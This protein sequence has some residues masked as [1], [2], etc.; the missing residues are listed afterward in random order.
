MNLNLSD[1]IPATHSREFGRE[2][3]V[4]FLNRSKTR[5]TGLVV[6]NK[7]ALEL[8]GLKDGD[9]VQV[10]AQK[11]ATQNPLNLLLIPGN[12]GVKV[13]FSD[14]DAKISGGPFFAATGGKFATIRWRPV[15][16]E[17]GEATGVLLTCLS[18][19]KRATA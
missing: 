4:S 8:I 13:T 1:W 3:L 5:S 14:H 19:E 9:R 15:P 12:D 6:I 2:P 18:S 16:V 10:M 17:A 11:K 7:A